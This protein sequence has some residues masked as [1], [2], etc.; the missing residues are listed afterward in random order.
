MKTLKKIYDGVVTAESYIALSLLAIAIIINA[1]EI[2]QRNVFGKSFIWNQEI[3]TLMLLWFALLGMAK[4]VNENADLCVDLFVKKFP[5]GAQKIIH[6]VIS[7]AIVAAFAII[8]YNTWL[9]FVSQAGNTSIIA[10]YPLQLRSGALL[11]G[12]TTIAIRYAA[13]LVQDILLLFRRDK[14]EG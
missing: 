4:I 13:D 5:A 7:A 10:K 1:Y 2:F 8:L 12:M 11:V 3:S 14:K 9:L 6:L